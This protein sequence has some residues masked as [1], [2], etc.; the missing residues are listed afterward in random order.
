MQKNGYMLV[1]GNEENLKSFVKR[2]TEQFRVSRN[3][4]N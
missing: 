3:G 1:Y 4:G 2:M